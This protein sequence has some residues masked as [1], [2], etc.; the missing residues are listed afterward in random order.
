MKNGLYNDF[1]VI[2]A[3]LGTAYIAL[4]I[5]LNQNCKIIVVAMRMY[6]EQAKYFH[7]N[8]IIS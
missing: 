7:R 3:S 2:Y 8:P 4:A 1:Q 5:Q 6:L